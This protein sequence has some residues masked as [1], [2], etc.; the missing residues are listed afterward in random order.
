MF[1]ARGPSNT[2][3]IIQSLLWLLLVGAAFLFLMRYEQVEGRRSMVPVRWP[4]SGSSA[5]SLQTDGYTLVLFAH[6]HCPCTEAT[7]SELSKLSEHH[8]NFKTYI[9]FLQPPG[10]TEKNWV[11][12]SLWKRGEALPNV[13]L[14]ADREGSICQ[15]FKATTSGLVLLYDP[16]GKLAFSGGITAARG[17]EGD[18]IG[19][20]SIANL[21]DGKQALTSSTPVF[22]C[23]LLESASPNDEVL[24]ACRN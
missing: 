5:M 23:S 9:V 11:R 19:E 12:S 21:L 24:R 8:K 1:A 3:T 13:S 7:L 17:H 15:K 16:M 4:D 22:G 10:L 20:D 14:I 6:P 2:S 18:N